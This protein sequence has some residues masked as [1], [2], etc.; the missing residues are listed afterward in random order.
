MQYGTKYLRKVVTKISQLK[1]KS[2]ERLACYK[3]LASLGVDG[4]TDFYSKKI[5]VDKSYR[6][7][8]FDK[9]RKLLTTLDFAVWVVGLITSDLIHCDFAEFD[10]TLIHRF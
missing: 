9:S 8:Q 1:L 10:V 7:N 3:S 4:L 6:I 2:H 5:H